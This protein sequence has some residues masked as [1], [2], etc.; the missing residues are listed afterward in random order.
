MCGCHSGQ[1]VIYAL[2]SSSPALKNVW[3]DVLETE[4]RRWLEVHGFT[5][6][7]ST[8]RLTHD[9]SLSDVPVQL[10]VIRRCDG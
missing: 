3:E 8:H 6:S 5:A 4:L 2:P 10:L 1:I 9:A 7:W